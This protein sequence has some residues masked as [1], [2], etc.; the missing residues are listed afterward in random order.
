MADICSCCG[1]KIP[2]LDVGFDVIEIDGEDFKI[3]SVCNGN[4][5]AYK[6]GNI[7]I[8]ELASDS[9]KQKLKQYFEDNAP[10]GKVVQEIKQQERQEEQRLQQ[11]LIA[12]ENDPLYDDIH[13]IAND[14]RLIK[15]VIIFGLVCGVVLGIISVLGMM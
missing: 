5:S 6:S 11:K 10:D 2:L 3:C 15:N 4:F 12:Q 7:G 13:Q 1:K 9:T 8:E 14:L